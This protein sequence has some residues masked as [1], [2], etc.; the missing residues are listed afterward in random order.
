M[1]ADFLVAAAAL[2][3]LGVF[4]AQAEDAASQP[5]GMPPLYVGRFAPV[6]QAPEG[7]GP[8]HAL[9]SRI[10]Q[11]KAD[12]N[13]AKLSSALVAALRKHQV[14]ADPL[15]EDP[16][17]RPHSGWL[18]QGIFYALD[19]NSRLISVPLLT[20]NKGPN[21]E[22]SV[23]VADFAMDPTMP[24]AVIGTDAALKGQGTA[25][26]WNP[27]VAAAKFVFY[28]AQGQDAIAVLADQIARKILDERPQLLAHDA[29]QSAT[30]PSR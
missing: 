25:I 18:V 28:Q 10:R 7:S 11:R 2:F 1:K 6:E 26:S 30:A 3:I 22:V 29:P 13:A 9:N 15:P 20:S 4:T 23:T 8:L 24:F 14:P 16:A 12:S 21:V 27:Y 19:E 5:P 17:L